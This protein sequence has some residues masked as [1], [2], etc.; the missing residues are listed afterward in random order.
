[1]LSK[2]DV[3][4][5]RGGWRADQ[6]TVQQGATPLPSEDYERLGLLLRLCDTCITLWDKTTD[7]EVYLNGTATVLKETLEK[8]HAAK[9]SLAKC[10]CWYP[11]HTTGGGETKDPVVWFDCCECPPCRERKQREDRKEKGGVKEVEGKEKP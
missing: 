9:E 7:L 4:L 10:K 11:Q 5:L 1:M 3:E 8:L 6:N 2:A